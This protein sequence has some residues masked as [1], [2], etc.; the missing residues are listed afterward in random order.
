MAR[1]PM[2]GDT[3][4]KKMY[5]II[6]YVPSWHEKRVERALTKATA[7]YEKHRPSVPEIARPTDTA[8][9]VTM[10]TEPPA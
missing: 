6:R 5:E 7:L 1:K 4:A 3:L 2:D 8:T 10:L 9:G